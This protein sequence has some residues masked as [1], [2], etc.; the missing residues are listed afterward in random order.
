MVRPPGRSRVILGSAI[1]MGAEVGYELLL[2][3]S[4]LVTDWPTH[5]HNATS[6]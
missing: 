3:L 1:I 5:T 2:V 4:G 6:F